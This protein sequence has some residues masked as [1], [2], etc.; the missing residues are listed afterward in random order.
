MGGLPEGDAGFA[1][2]VSCAIIGILDRDVDEDP[3][4]KSCS[5]ASHARQGEAFRVAYSPRGEPNHVDLERLPWTER[6]F[7]RLGLRTGPNHLAALQARAGVAQAISPGTF[8]GGN[9]PVLVMDDDAKE[10]GVRAQGAWTLR[11]DER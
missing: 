1:A 10:Y 3:H 9:D 2:L 5:G 4:E 7:R 11:R 8:I 6:V